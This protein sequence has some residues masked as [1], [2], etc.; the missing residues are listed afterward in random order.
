MPRMASPSAIPAIGTAMLALIRDAVPKPELATATFELVQLKDLQTPMDDGIGLYLHRIT[1]ASAPR[2]L[3]PRAAGS[4]PFPPVEID[5]HYLLVA[6]AGDASRQQRLLG[7]AMHAIGGTPILSAA[8][9]NLHAGETGLFQ[10]K[11][12]ADVLLEPLSIQDQGTIWQGAKAQM[13]P[14]A[15]YV[16][17]NLSL[18]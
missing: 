8:F 14:C 9:L 12:F 10:E 4:S 5:L 11:E 16:V 3:P 13:Q 1:P 2:K 17:R 18:A 7:W 6:W 15:A